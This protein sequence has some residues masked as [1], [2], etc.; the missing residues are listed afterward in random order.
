M[1]RGGP[2]EPELI[3]PTTTDLT[4]QGLLARAEAGRHAASDHLEDALTA[5]VATVG[6]RRAGG[7]MAGAPGPNTFA[8]GVEIANG[9]PEHL[10]ILE[11]SGAAVPPVHADATLLVVPAHADPELVAGYLGPAMLLMADLVVVTLAPEPLSQAVHALEDRI[12]ELVPQVPLVH[13][14]FQPNPLG[15]VSGRSIFFTTTAP[16]GA[17]ATLA[18]HLEADHGARVVGVST[19]LANRKLLTEDLKAAEGAEVLVTELKAAA[20][21]VAG[22]VALEAGMQVVFC[23][24]QPVG[25]GGDGVLDELLLDLVHRAEERFHSETATRA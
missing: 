5:R 9:R 4:P 20:V 23:D 6:T 7:G 2:A 10:T 13:T 16:P 8:A 25:T 15:P 14:T 24:N 18:A 17:A 21:D 12:R 19:N 22:R 1:G 3:D 11:G